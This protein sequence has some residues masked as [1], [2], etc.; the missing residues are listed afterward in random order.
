M[1]QVARRL[2]EKQKELEERLS[3]GE[4]LDDSDFD[5]EG[6]EDEGDVFVIQVLRCVGVNTYFSVLFL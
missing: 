2:A 3:K 4:E 6:P 1:L 5:D